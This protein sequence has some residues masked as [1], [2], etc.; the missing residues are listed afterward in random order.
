MAAKRPTKRAKRP[1]ADHRATARRVL[2]IEADAVRALKGKLTADFD[3]A[4]EIVLGCTG[5]LIVTGMGKSGHICNK[6]AATFASTGTPSFFVHPAEGVHGDLGM[7][8]KGDAVLAVS[9]SGE[10]E[11]VKKIL[12]IVRR[13]GVPIVG[14]TGNLRSTLAKYADVTLDVSVKE[15][16][17]PLGLAPTASTTA[18]LALGDALAVTVLEARGFK[19]ED[20][21]LYHPAGTLGK[22]LLLTVEEL[23]HAGEAFP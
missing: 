13:M 23:M 8:G 18:A 22:K 12:P 2:D 7:I 1:A 9:F 11:E 3:R 14:M 6:L 20:F 21:A 16:A 5:K 19:A 17:C 10:T 4:V 15:E